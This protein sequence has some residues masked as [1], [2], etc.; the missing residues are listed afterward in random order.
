MSTKKFTTSTKGDFVVIKSNDGSKIIGKIE[1][2]NTQNT[3]TTFKYNEYI[4]PE[5]TS[6]KQVPLIFSRQTK[7]QL[8][9]R[10]LQDR[11]HSRG[12]YR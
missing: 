1:E 6:S 8:K 4:F 9:V 11:Q 10:D 7:P 5:K 2:I 3:T 12:G